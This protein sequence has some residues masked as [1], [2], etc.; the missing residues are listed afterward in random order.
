VFTGDVG[1]YRRLLE[2]RVNLGMAALYIEATRAGVVANGHLALFRYLLQ[3]HRHCEASDPR[4]MIYAF[5]GLAWKERLPFTAYPEAIVPDYKISVQKLY[6]TVVKAMLLS[7]KDLRFLSHVQDPAETAIENLPS[8]VPDF[9]VQLTPGLL[10]SLGNCNWNAGGKLS[11]TPDSR[12]LDVG[13]LYVAG[14]LLDTVVEA[15][16]F[17]SPYEKDYTDPYLISALNLARNLNDC[18]PLASTERCV[19]LSSYLHVKG[20]TESYACTLC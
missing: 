8:W 9:S 16:V 19:N 18:Y 4:D 20:R 3:V 2:A 10:S 15:A 11:W 6:T 1:R 17:I 14:V 12:G 7:Y 5:L 13:S